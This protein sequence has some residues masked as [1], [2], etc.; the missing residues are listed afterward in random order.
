MNYDASEDAS[1]FLQI[2]ILIKNVLLACL[3]S[4]LTL[5][6]IEII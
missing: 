5:Q 4:K 2:E 1:V 6:Y 3:F